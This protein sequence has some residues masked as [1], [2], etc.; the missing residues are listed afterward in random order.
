MLAVV[1]GAVLSVLV[2]VKVLDMGFF[3]AFDRPFDPV[4][5]WSYA[6]IGIETLRDAIGSSQRERSPSP[7]RSCSSSRSSS[8]RSWRCCA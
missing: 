1:V 7:S 5:D 3:T 4:D 8:S 2:L 6:G